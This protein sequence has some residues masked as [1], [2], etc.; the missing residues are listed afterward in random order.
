MGG[1][2]GGEGSALRDPKREAALASSGVPHTVVR[3]G[4]PPAMLGCC[5]KPDDGDV[6]T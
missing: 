4:E 5:N 1:L 2:L 6:I 3:A